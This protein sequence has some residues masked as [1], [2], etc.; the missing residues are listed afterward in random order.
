MIQ[1]AFNKGKRCAFEV[2]PKKRA[3]CA[4]THAQSFAGMRENAQE[5]SVKQQQ[6]WGSH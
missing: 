1:S 2:W 5:F 3:I 4:S 6:E